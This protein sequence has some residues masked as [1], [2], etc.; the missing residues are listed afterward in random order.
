MGIITLWNNNPCMDKTEAIQTIIRLAK[1][2]CPEL[3]SLRI[4]ISMNGGGNT[5]Y[6]S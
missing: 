5:L 3:F 4:E 1:H 6:F 2:N